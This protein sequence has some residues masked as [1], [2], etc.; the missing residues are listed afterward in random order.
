MYRGE[1]WINL[2]LTLGLSL[3]MISQGIECVSKWVGI[4]ANLDVL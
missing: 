3:E 2:F 4:A 1:D